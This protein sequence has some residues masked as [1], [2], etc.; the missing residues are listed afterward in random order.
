MLSGNCGEGAEA[1]IDGP[2]KK[3]L[4][5]RGRG[6]AA[7]GFRDA[8]HTYGVRNLLLT[9]SLGKVEP[10]IIAAMTEIPRALISMGNYVMW[11]STG[12]EEMLES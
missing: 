10:I 3:H 4:A 5:G 2:E 1:S 9:Y 7:L 6:E 8:Q 11:G 12:R